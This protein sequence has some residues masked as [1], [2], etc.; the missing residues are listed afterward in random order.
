[1]GYE[2]LGYAY[3]RRKDGTKI[4]GFIRALSVHTLESGL[5]GSGLVVRL[6]L[7]FWGQMRLGFWDSI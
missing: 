1:M 7:F 4:V 6:L 2:S 5:D 3:C